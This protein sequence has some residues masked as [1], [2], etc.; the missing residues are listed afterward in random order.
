M[1]AS[2]QPLSA[3]ALGK[4]AVLYGGNAAE[5]AI[6]IQS[7]EA[8][9]AALLRQGVNAVG[10]DTQQGAVE[11]L[12]QLKPDRAFIAL[13]GVGGEDGKIQAV[14][15]Y[16]GIPYTGSGVMASALCMDKLMTKRLWQAMGLPTPAYVSLSPNQDWAKVLAS[17]GGHGQTGSR[18]IQHWDEPR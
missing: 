5:R 15:E 2:I 14:L 16:L 18:R 10:I 3:A 13:H 1:K 6:S 9:L 7:G 4:V 11:A 8:A 17:L 12:Q